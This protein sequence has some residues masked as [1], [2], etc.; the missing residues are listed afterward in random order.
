M[1]VQSHWFM[2]KLII[3][4]V[5]R[6]LP[7]HISETAFIAGSILADYSLIT[8]RHK[9]LTTKS[10]DFIKKN[11][12][13]MT[14]IGPEFD[15]LADNYLVAYHLGTITHYICDFFCRAHSGETFGNTREHMQY[16]DFLDNWRRT[17]ADALEARDWMPD[18]T[19]LRS[20]DEI[21]QYLDDELTQYRSEGQSVQRDIE[22][23]ISNS[24]AILYSM[25]VI[26]LT[27]TE[28]APSA[29]IATS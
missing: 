17:H 26:R 5:N 23:A 24:I 29:A 3:R 7:V 8:L 2:S 19:A 16:E 10:L 22:L 25:A 18:F 20:A 28:L 15:L 11:I 4:E 27:Q 14:N 1:N 12:Q 6:R 21:V 9:H 13:F